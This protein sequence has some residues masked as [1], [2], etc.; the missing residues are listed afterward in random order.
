VD[1]ENS[2]RA[3]FRERKIDLPLTFFDEAGSTNT[4][5]KRAAAEGAPDSFFIARRQSAGRG[6]LGRSFISPEGGIYMSY[7]CHPDMP[8]RDA[9]MLTAYA[10][11]AV[12]EAIEEL[13]SA[14]PGI[15]WVNDVYLGGKKLS[16]ILTEGAFSENGESFSYAV[17]GIGI[18]VL[19]RPMPRDVAA[20]A[21][22]LEDECEKV[23]DIASLAAAVACRLIRF[24]EVP[25]SEY[26]E[27]YKGA[28]VITGKRVYV[29][30]ADNAYFARAH[31]V[32]DDA[33]LAVITDKGE[34]I[35]LRSG[36]V[37]VK[38]N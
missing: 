24:S 32:L 1:L 17:I 2:L 31:R 37:T 38:I 18:N 16:G 15:K 9:V 14:R 13:T 34:E 8:P 10:A 23:P 19:S 30:A 21:T 4:E 28:S 25:R 5:A 33:S 22:S 6:R 36:E 11:V 12:C 20:I 26:M 3:A 35:I 29:T 7:L 27:K